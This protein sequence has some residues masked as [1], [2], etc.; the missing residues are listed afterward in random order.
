M[1]HAAAP[2]ARFAFE[3]L[4]AG[5]EPL[6]TET[7]MFQAQT[8]EV[9]LAQ[10]LDLPP[11]TP[12]QRRS[13]L[14][15]IPELTASLVRVDRVYRMDSGGAVP[16]AAAAPAASVQS[17]STAE[18]TV[19]PTT[20]RTG[21]AV[22]DAGGGQLLWDNAMIAD[23]LMVQVEDGITRGKLQSALPQGAVVRDAITTRGLYLVA[24]PAEGE[25]AVERAVLSLSGLKG[26][27]RFAEP[28]F[29]ICGADTTPND[30]LFTTSASNTTKQWHLAKIMAPRAWDVIKQP[31][32]ATIANQT[33]VAVVDTGVDYTHPDLAGNIWTNP[34]ESGGGKENNGVDDDGNGKIDDLRGWNFVELSNE[35]MD[36]VG[37]GTHVAGIIGAVGNNATGATG[38]CWGG[39]ILPLRIIK[40]VSGGTYGTYSAA[41]GAL[42]YIR[43]LNTSGR[44]VAVANHS[45]GGSGYSLAMLNVINNPVVTGDPLPMG[46][47]ST[48]LASVN[49]F[50]VAGSGTEIAKIKTGMT[51]TGP[52]IPSGTLVTIVSGSSL[53]L[54]D[55]T[56]MP[57]TNGA[58]V[59]SNPI[60][61]KPYGVVHVAAAG[62]SQFNCDRIPVY[63]AC[64]PSGFIV[65]VGATDTSDNPAVWA[66][67]A[68]SNFGRLN[69]DIFAPGS[70]IWSTKWKAPG[71][72]SYGYESRN[73]TSMAAPQVAGALA[74]VRMWQPNL[75]ELQAR[76][77]LIEQSDQVAGL[78]GKC[79]SNGRLNIAKVIDRLYQ[80]I[81]VSSSGGT[82]GSSTLTEALQG[83]MG[84]VGRVAVGYYGGNSVLVVQNGQV[85]AWGE[86]G[87][88]QLGLGDRLN[89]A[90]PVQIPG[91]DNVLQVAIGS[92]GSS[93]A[94]RADGTV[95]AWGSN[96]NGELGTGV[97]NE[98]YRLSPAQV[99]GV[100]D[101]VWISAGSGY[102]LAVCADGTVWGWGLNSKGQLGVGDFDPH[103]VPIQSSLMSNVSQVD[104]GN[105]HAIALKSDGSV[106][107][108]GDRTYG[109]TSPGDGIQ[110]GA[111]G[112]G[113]KTGYSAT[114]VHVET[115]PAAT[116]VAAG[117]GYSSAITADGF[118]YEW[119]YV[120][121]RLSAAAQPA[122]PA[123]RTG[124][125]NIT[126]ICAA[127]DNRLAVD[128]EGRIWEWGGMDQG[129]GGL[130][131]DYTDAS[132]PMEL[133]TV[134]GQ[135]MA[136]CQVGFRFGMV[137]GVDGAVYTFGDNAAGSLG[138]GRFADKT[139]PV[140]LG[141]LPPVSSVMTTG[142]N[143]FVT[144]GGEFY[145]NGFS[146]FPVIESGSFGGN[147][148][149]AVPGAS[150]GGNFLFLMRKD[151]SVYSL[152][153]NELGQLGLGYFNSN[154]DGIISGLTNL[155][156]LAAPSTGTSSSAFERD[157]Q[158]HA[159]AALSDGSVRAWGGNFYGQVG[160]G[161]TTNRASPTLLSGLSDVEAVAAGHFHNLALTS[162]G[163]VYAWGRNDKGQ[164]GDG[165]QQNRLVPQQ[166]VGVSGIVQVGAIANQSFALQADGSLWAWGENNG[167][168]LD[169]ALAVNVQTTPVKI[170]GLPPISKIFPGIGAH[171][172]TA[173]DGRLWCWG[174]TSDFIANKLRALDPATTVP[175]SIPTP[176]LGM[177]SVKELSTNGSTTFAVKTDGSVFAWGYGGYGAL[178]DG[179]GWATLPSKVVT[180]TGTS[181]VM[182]T[183]G[184]G[185]AVDS[186]LLKNFSAPDLLDDSQVSDLASPAGDGI[187]NLLKYAL[188]LNP[189]TRCDA[190]SLPSLRVDLI[191]GSAQS[192]SVR[193]GIGLFSVPTVD[194]T[195]GK[196]YIAFTVPRNGIHTDVNYI[197]EVSTDL[198]NWRSGDPHTVTVLD[199]A[200]TL[201]VYSATAVEDSPRQFMRLKIQRK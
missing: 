5:R 88:G 101:A 53:T 7:R 172:A 52:G 16:S 187:P 104:A 103:L 56:T 83:S 121:F 6:K 163:L 11:G 18:V 201:E 149:R 170:S 183:L 13:A 78:S 109:S 1:D 192:T 116:F 10:A 135:S 157:R 114:P 100:A 108:W 153:A 75:T 124:L 186:W 117:Q 25:R 46:I 47:T 154:S 81:L 129:S 64:L 161:S 96:S 110:V 138:I 107:C 190:S 126:V 102:A 58:L 144:E 86:N 48:Y 23:H 33:V 196:H 42:D 74:L 29:L 122:S 155:R 76:Q 94:L 156:S 123:L 14:Y 77:V 179:D 115:L 152:R 71:D 68:G 162:G 195:N 73:G 35:V 171:Y 137:V 182:S 197:V 2:P 51:I 49:T 151:G 70:S 132:V 111:L 191:G 160:D 38:V 180:L 128:S 63:P 99:V 4:I 130:G 31:K 173:A 168:L 176:V 95:W 59:F 36:D 150:N 167:T 164:V 69:V 26:V 193:G 184:A 61:P 189:K 134:G 67:G 21:S 169:A 22:L 139:L 41:I 19:A 141:A 125:T 44:K 145:H 65:S 87:V 198:V 8:W 175:L 147:I 113:L 106:W 30:P 140:R 185:S 174:I 91:L 57:A 12:L 43:T 143:Y 37:H 166:V 194:L 17:P 133:V 127:Y 55:Y 62:N 80:P 82:G 34:G 54:S 112:D 98:F 93:L 84:I 24:V 66:G 131:E 199:T 118:V 92:S 178:G 39:K 90:T 28:D 142:G 120:D 119:G 136:S 20:R 85:L 27:V 15:R 45:W 89:R 97:A 188:G 60:R 165:T 200:E 9:D 79:V 72:P 50:T 177:N 40:A 32:T 105:E 159:V 3:A 158:G 181:A 148:S 146:R